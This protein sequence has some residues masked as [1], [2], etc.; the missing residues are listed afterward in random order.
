LPAKPPLPRT[1]VSAP[2]RD[3]AVSVQIYEI[4]AILLV[5][6]AI[7]WAA[8]AWDYPASAM[9]MALPY[10]MGLSLIPFL[11]IWVVMMAAMMFPT[12]APMILTFHGIQSRR[13]ARGA[14]FA[15]WAFVAGYLLLWAL[16]G[17]AAYALACGAEAAAAYFALSARSFARFGGALLVLAGLYQFTPTKD[18]CLSKCRTPIAF[19][20]TAWQGGTAGA[21]RMGWLHG[22]HCFGCCWLL[23]AI[24]FPLG[25]MNVTAMAAIT[26][27]VLAEKMFPWG[28][29]IARAAAAVLIAYGAA[30]IATPRLLP[31]FSA[32]AGMAQTGRLMGVSD[33]GPNGLL[34]LT[35]VP[36]GTDFH[37][38]PS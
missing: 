32:H 18:F 21:L 30:V 35:Q 7:C 19:I 10:S 24:L 36:F 27:L 34:M 8:L 31:T 13:T 23:F 26:L 17:I 15:T 4:L 9:N 25:M 1:H 2:M 3:G 11:A 12:A 37:D 20:M 33:P 22:L 16:T 5:V 14:F 29:L 28:R 38:W 6:A